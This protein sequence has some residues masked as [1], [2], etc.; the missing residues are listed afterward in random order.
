[1]CYNAELLSEVISYH[2]PLL[3]MTY[4]MWFKFKT[5]SMYY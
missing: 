1:M 3:E 2:T 5:K 4:F